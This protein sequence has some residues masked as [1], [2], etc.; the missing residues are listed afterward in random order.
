MRER[1]RLSFYVGLNCLEIK[2]LD[3]Q[4]FLLRR[5]RRAMDANRRVIDLCSV[6]IELCERRN[7]IP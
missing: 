6:T 1:I 5:V 4:L 2:L 3:V 7:K